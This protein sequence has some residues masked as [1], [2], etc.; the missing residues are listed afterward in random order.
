ME[1]SLSLRNSHKM[2]Q[3]QQPPPKSNTKYIVAAIVGICLLV[4]I[5]II[6]GV[7]PT[8]LTNKSINCVGDWEP[9]STLATCG[10]GT[11]KYKIKTQK[12]GDGTACSYADGDTENCKIR[13][14]PVN[15]DV[16]VNCVGEWEPCSVTCG[17]GT[18]RYRV[19]TLKQYDGQSCPYA[20]NDLRTCKIADCPV[21]VKRYP[22]G[23]LTS[24]STTLT[25]YAYGN[26]LYTSSASTVYPGETEIDWKA[27][28]YDNSTITDMWTA[29]SSYHLNIPGTATTIIS[30]TT[31]TG[32]WLQ[33]KLPIPIV[34]SNYNIYTRVNDL[35]RG[36]KDFYIGGSNDGSTWFNVD[37]RT[38]ITSYTTSGKPFVISS[39]NNIPYSYYRIVV[40]TNNGSWLS[41][42]EWE[43]YGYE[44]T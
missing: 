3:P 4:F 31:Y 7:I 20:N 36:P 15:V 5:L 32:D 8:P 22:P 34:L 9:C 6:I 18:K 30:G 26:G 23:P 10:N 38:G 25:N 35:N 27:F 43:L 14:C 12:Q 16:N 24:S 11:K 19:R 44:P 33:I 40:L 37:S 17:N 39:S 42:C 2:Q 13:D 29:S 1:S 41:I 21:I 28:N